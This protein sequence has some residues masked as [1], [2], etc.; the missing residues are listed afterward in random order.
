MRSVHE[1]RF[2]HLFMN[3]EFGVIPYEQFQYC[4]KLYVFIPAGTPLLMVCG[5]QLQESGEVR[6][7]V[8]GIAHGFSMVIRI[9]RFGV[10][11][12]V[13]YGLSLTRTTHPAG[14][15]RSMID[16]LTHGRRYT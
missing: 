6:A 11:L 15:P 2:V 1:E 10:K 9:Q 12:A 7:W 16:Y 8:A 4:S 3:D 14:I 5:W 13:T